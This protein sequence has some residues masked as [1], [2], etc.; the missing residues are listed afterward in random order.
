VL[1]PGDIVGEDFE[2]QG[3]LS[4]GGMG[5]LFVARQRSTDA[6]RV[7]KVM[8]PNLVQSAELRERFEREARASGRIGS[9]HVVKTIAYGV[10]ARLGI[11]WLAMEYLEGATLEARLAEFGVPAKGVAFELLRQLFHGVAAAHAAG[12]VHRDLK[13][14]NVFVADA[15]RADV[16]FTVKV[17]DFGIAKLMTGAGQGTRAMGTRAWMAPEQEQNDAAID[18][19]ADVWALG[20]VVFWL[21]SGRSFWRNAAGPES[22][23]SY[24]VH[25]EPIAQ[26]SSR[27]VE[28]GSGLAWDAFDAWFSHC[29]TRDPS[30]RFRDAWAAWQ[31]LA[32][33]FTSIPYWGPGGPR[34]QAAAPR[35]SSG[36]ATEPERVSAWPEVLGNGPAP[37]E[38]AF[39]T[40]TGKTTTAPMSAEPRRSEGAAA[41]T[42][43]FRTAITLAAGGLL[44][45]GGTFLA[46]SLDSD[47]SS[48][49]PLVASAAL[50]SKPA[51]LA[52]P[53]RAVAP[54]PT[55]PDGMVY[56]PP[57][58][59]SM[60]NGAAPP[61]GPARQ[62]RI[63]R[64]FFIDRYEASV[65]EYR[66]CIKAKRCTRSGIHGPRPTQEE[67]EKYTEFCT[68]I[69]PG[70][71][72]MPISCI[73][74]AQA[75]AYCAFRNKRLP[76]EAEWEYAARGSDGRAYPW[77]NDPPARC[78]TA[79]ISG[80][81]PATGPRA[82]GLRDP[83]SAS[84]FGAFDMS[85]NVWEWVKDAY[86]PQAHTV[87]APVD[88]LVRGV[89]ERGVLRG[90]SWDFA[91]THARTWH[92]QPFDR[93]EGHVGTGVRCAADAETGKAAPTAR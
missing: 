86:D 35:S 79:V 71:D 84:P 62:V 60:G 18:A 77:G 64:G 38:Q 46:R 17:L 10:D 19:S 51:P 91:P 33:V 93:R 55:P 61:R 56:V 83:S 24:E 54:P 63:S 21:L 7:V 43:L 90:G 20:L 15:R 5:A 34:P 4:R 81:C 37:N 1:R 23:L 73:D 88:P 57:G 92:R 53:S 28:L 52:E 69:E 75:T 40:A 78:S 6:A 41:S 42:G 82:V 80:L 85:G 45:A 8:L 89:G 48:T 87:S 11:P 9:E 31:A 26:A 29:V 2:V 27:A 12:I 70:H 22:R 25:F 36:P 67:I 59:F 72:G 47:A 14:G 66:A 74:H 32:N 65:G 50:D 13:P 16:P 49:E 68:G 44:V 58:T 76:T 3:P 30:L 39:L